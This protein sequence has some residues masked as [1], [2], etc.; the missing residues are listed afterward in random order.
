[1]QISE[2]NI[3]KN[4]KFPASS[5]QKRKIQ[6]IFKKDETKI[7]PSMAARAFVG[8]STDPQSCIRA[9]VL[10]PISNCQKLESMQLQVGSGETE[11]ATT[12]HRK[13]VVP[14]DLKSSLQEYA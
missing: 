8:V 11:G 10:G 6:I 7:A 14:Q 4:E 12:I 1:M 5:S 9:Y 3:K 13:W 2:Y